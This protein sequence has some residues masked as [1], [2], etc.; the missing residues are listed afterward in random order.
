M[1]NAALFAEIMANTLI[2]LPQFIKLVAV[3][4]E[5]LSEKY[6]RVYIVWSQGCGG[7]SANETKKHRQSFPV[8]KT[9]T[10]HVFTMILPWV[11]LSSFGYSV[12]L[13]HGLTVE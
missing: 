7:L 10:M 1:S 9:S 6:N 4:Y 3:E 12:Y 11:I 8:S 2:F 5:I 13:I